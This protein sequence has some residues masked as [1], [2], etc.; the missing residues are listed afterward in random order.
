MKKILGFMFLC[1]VMSYNVNADDISEFQINGMS[2]GDSGLKYFSESE[3]KNNRQKKWYNKNN[4]STSTINGINVSYKTKDKEYLIVSLE[5]S[6]TMNIDKCLERLPKEYELIKNL[7]RANVE[8]K[9][10]IKTKHWADKS[11]MSWYEGYYFY[12]PNKDIISV[13]CYNWSDKIT[14]NKG[15]GDHLRVMITA[16]EFNNFLANQ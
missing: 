10:P 13:E 2:I 15:W 11:K 9:G 8:I 6:E 1:F 7:F 14:S 16:K 3:L 4:Y 5:K 12:F